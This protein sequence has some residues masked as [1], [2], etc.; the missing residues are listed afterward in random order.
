MLRFLNGSLRTW[1]L[2]LVATLVVT[3]QAGTVMARTSRSFRPAT[4]DA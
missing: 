1:H 2:L 4:S 3:L